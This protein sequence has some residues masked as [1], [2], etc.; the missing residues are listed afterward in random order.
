[1]DKFIVELDAQI[2]GHEQGGGADRGGPSSWDGNNKDGANDVGGSV[3]GEDDGDYL[4]E[5]FG[6][7]D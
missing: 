1:M 6:P 3:R 4:E 5:C 7:L 2:D